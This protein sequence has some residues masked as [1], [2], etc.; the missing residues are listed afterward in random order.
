MLKITVPGEE[1][2]DPVKER[3]YI[4]KAADLTMEHSLISL[5]KWEQKYKKPFLPSSP[6]APVNVAPEEMLDYIRFMTLTQ[7]VDPN[8]Y[9]ALTK[10]NIEQ[11][12]DYMADPMTATTISKQ[13]QKKGP[14]RVITSE[15]IYAWMA[16]LRIPYTCE[17]WHLNRLLTLIQVTSIEQEPPDQ[18]KPNPRQMMS[19]QQALNRA[20]RQRFKSKG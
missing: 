12:K 9:N 5:S 2:Y 15:L 20:R 19:Q 16:I 6:L 4:V 17:K 10:E 18:K 7:N 14:P 8:V 1:L 13:N 3:F 11:I